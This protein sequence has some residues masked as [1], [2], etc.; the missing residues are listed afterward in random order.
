MILLALNKSF[1]KNFLTSNDVTLI[2]FQ[3]R[4]TLK[5]QWIGVFPVV[6]LCDAHM[7]QTVN[8]DENIFV[9][10]LFIWTEQKV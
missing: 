7:F 8:V 4:V 10:I 5:M 9:Q 3:N 2:V 1:K 6:Q